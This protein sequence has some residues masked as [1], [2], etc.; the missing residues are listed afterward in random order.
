MQCEQRVGVLGAERPP[1][2]GVAGLQHHR[3]PLGCWR[4]RR[5]PA[6]VEVRAVVLDLA[7]ASGIDVDSAVA[8]GEDRVGGPAVPEFARHDDELLGALIAVSVVE[9]SATAEVLTGECIR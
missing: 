3:M 6:H 7:N 8:V 9:E 5:N 1:V 4:P 2:R